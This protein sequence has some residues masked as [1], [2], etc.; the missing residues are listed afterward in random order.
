MRAA[1]SAASEQVLRTLRTIGYTEGQVVLAPR[2]KR[3][4]DDRQQ[5]FR[6]LAAGDRPFPISRHPKYRSAKAVISSDCGAAP[7]KLF[8]SASNPSIIPCVDCSF[9]PVNVFS[10]RV[11][12]Y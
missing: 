1:S 5:S 11:S 2:E 9:T 3:K 8:T 4:S 12:V 6:F 7:V 10:S